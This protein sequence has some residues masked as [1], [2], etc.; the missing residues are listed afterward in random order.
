ML[1]LFYSRGIQTKQVTNKPYYNN[2]E[3]QNQ[4]SAYD[5]PSTSSNYLDSSTTIIS[6]SKNENSRNNQ[7][8]SSDNY[9]LGFYMVLASNDHLVFAHLQTD[10][11]TKFD[12]R[13]SQRGEVYIHKIENGFGYVDEGNDFNAHY[14]LDMNDLSLVKK[15]K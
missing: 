12:F 2:Q 7:T 14:W 6:P 15:M 5:R 3:N 1:L 9:P 11:N 4:T 13:Y 10:I 8:I